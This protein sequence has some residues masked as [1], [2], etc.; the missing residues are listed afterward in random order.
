MMAED[1][2]PDPG[3]LPERDPN[4][5]GGNLPYT[6]DQTEDTSCTEKEKGRSVPVIL[7]HIL[8]EEVENFLRAFATTLLILTLFSLLLFVTPFFIGPV[9]AFFIG[10][11]VAG[12]K[13]GKRTE[14][15]AL[16]GLISGMIWASGEVILI[17]SIA[18]SISPV[19]MLVIDNLEIMVIIFIYISNLFFCTLGGLIGS[20]KRVLVRRS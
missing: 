20:R 18:S 8:D 14:Q 5:P 11:Y 9:F 19:G 7:D 15:G 13:G 2:I 17:V 12:Y 3:H 1:P 16:M 10:P 4:Y 6:G